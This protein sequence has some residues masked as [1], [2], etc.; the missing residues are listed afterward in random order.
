MPWF[1]SQDPVCRR[2]RSTG[3]NEKAGERSLDSE[4]SACALAERPLASPF[5]ALLKLNISDCA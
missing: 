2:S 4:L 5:A 3:I 1:S